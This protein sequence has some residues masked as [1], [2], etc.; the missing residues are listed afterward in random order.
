MEGVQNYNKSVTFITNQREYILFYS[1]QLYVIVHARCIS[2]ASDRA[3]SNSKEYT[4]YTRD[5]VTCSTATSI[6]FPAQVVTW[7]DRH[8]VDNKLR[9]GVQAS[10]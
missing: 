3:R 8:N 9:P 7:I 4:C 2:M 1:D 5:S 6:Y 10:G